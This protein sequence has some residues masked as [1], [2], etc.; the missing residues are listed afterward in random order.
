MKSFSQKNHSLRTKLALIHLEQPV[1]QGILNAAITQLDKGEQEQAVLKDVKK[2]FKKLALTQDL[3][4]KGLSLYTELQKP[5]VSIDTA[6]S[7][8]TWFP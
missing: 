8:M 3:S 7:S 1:E 2:H 6:L 4:Q 5:N